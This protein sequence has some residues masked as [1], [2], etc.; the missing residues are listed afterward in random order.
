MALARIELRALGFRWP[1]A[2]GDLL[3]IPQL[4]LAAGERC[5]VHGESGCGKSTLLG[6]LAGVLRPT[7]GEHHF[8]GQRF[9]SLAESQRDAA[10]ADHI[11][12]LFQQFNLLPYLS[13]VDNVMLPCRLS[14]V[15]RNRVLAKDRTPRAEA[16]RMLAALGVP[17]ARWPQ[18]SAQLSV[19]EQQR[20]AA[21]RA[22]IG[23]PELVLADEPTSALDATRQQ[24]F[25]ALLAD[26][27]AQSGATLVFVS[28]D[29]RL[30]AGFDTVLSL[31]DFA[32]E[33]RA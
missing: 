24:E 16:E 13:A 1:G 22:L 18:R 17:A 3:H 5:F 27:A 25:L 8:L 6:L 29:M 12:Y 31:Q 20:V 21:A 14:T 2:G 26:E 15:R 9:D 33:V 30:A 11:G 19:G 28:H 7:C 23:S 10:R 4:T 32:P